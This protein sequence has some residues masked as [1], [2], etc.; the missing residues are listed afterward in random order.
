MAKCVLI[1]VALLGLSG[2]A[3][4]VDPRGADPQLA[5]RCKLMAHSEDRTSISVGALAM[6]VN[7]YNADERRQGIYDSCVAAQGGREAPP[8]TL[9]LPAP[10][11]AVPIPEQYVPGYGPPSG[12]TGPGQPV[13]SGSF[14]RSFLI[15]GTDTS[16][17]VGG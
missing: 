7:A 11:G 16:I 5:A 9:P 10:V 12:P 8:E 3:A 14:P 1:T 13:V 6:A 17:R 2:C 15:P 4:P